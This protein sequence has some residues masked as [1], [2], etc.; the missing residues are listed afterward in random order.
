MDREKLV[1]YFIEQM[2]EK[3]M[4][5]NL[6]KQNVIDMNKFLEGKPKTL[7]RVGKIKLNKNGKRNCSTK[8]Q[9]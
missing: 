6:Y 7:N 2:K 8:K 1:T 3:Q 9:Y 4:L 5:D